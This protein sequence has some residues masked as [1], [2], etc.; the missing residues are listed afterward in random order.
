MC[1]SVAYNRRPG[2]SSKW[3][4]RVRRVAIYLRDNFLCA[5][6]GRSLV[7]LPPNAVTLDHVRP[8]ALGGSNVSSNL[9][10]ACARCNFTRKAT[11]VRRYA[12]P[13][14]L[15]RINRVRRRTLNYALARAV[16]TGAVPAR[17]AALENTR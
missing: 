2:R 9:V 10:T 12:T 16:I 1:N 3:I 15:A 4:T 11:P 14:A 13:A 5:Y 8:R 7:G 17:V 6:C